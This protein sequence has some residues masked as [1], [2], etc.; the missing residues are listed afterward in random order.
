MTT[1]DRDERRRRIA[2]ITVDVIAREG[3]EAATIR[4][5]AAELQGP[6]KLITH[7]FAD[8]EQL[9][10][11]A[12]DALAAQWERNIEAVVLNDPADILGCLYCMA[13]TTELQVKLWRVYVAFWDWTARNDVVASLQRKNI[14]LALGRISDIVRARNGERPDL[15]SISERLNAIVQGLAI[16]AL[17]DSGKWPP[18]RIRQRLTE[19]VDL[20]LGPS[21]TR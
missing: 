21:T 14:N 11:W 18:A 5:I 6:T 2:E 4:R 10:L 7:Y 12:Y 17:M 9:L 1:I 15:E 20:L 16:Q 13:P 3:L 8:K 19:E